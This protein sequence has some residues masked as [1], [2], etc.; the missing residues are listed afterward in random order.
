M[1]EKEERRLQDRV[2]RFLGHLHLIILDR[3]SPFQEPQNTETFICERGAGLGCWAL[4]VSPCG[5]PWRSQIPGSWSGLLLVHSIIPFALKGTEG[6][7]PA[8]L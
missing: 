4:L 2:V 7:G 5:C 6:S 3:L 8:P 1:S